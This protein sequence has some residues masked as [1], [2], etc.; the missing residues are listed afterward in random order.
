M[1]KIDLLGGIYLFLIVFTLF[2]VILAPVPNNFD[3]VNI[4]DGQLEYEITD[5]LPFVVIIDNTGLLGSSSNESILIHYIKYYTLSYQYFTSSG[6]TEGIIDVGAL[7]YS[8]RTFE[9]TE[10]SRVTSINFY[11]DVPFCIAITTENEID[12]FKEDVNLFKSG[13]YVP[14][15]VHTL[16]IIIFWV[17]TMVFAI[18]FTSKN[19]TIIFRNHNHSNPKNTAKFSKLDLLPQ[20]KRIIQCNS[21]GTEYVVV[22]DSCICGEKTPK[23]AIC[24]NKF[25]GDDRYIFLSCCLRYV[26]NNEIKAWIVKKNTCPICKRDLKTN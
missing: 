24:Y 21:C 14:V 18:N 25:N 6:S 12:D 16:I 2:W 7:A 13:N 19:R 11:A 8:Y 15:S 10:S 22:N 9:D 3:H 23:C 26:H 1:K 4:L 20:A 5:N 17:Y